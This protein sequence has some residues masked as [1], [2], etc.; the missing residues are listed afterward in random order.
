MHPPHFGLGSYKNIRS[1]VST[2]T[3][4]TTAAPTTGDLSITSAPTMAQADGAPHALA[5]GQF[6]H[7]HA[8]S[9]EAHC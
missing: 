7:R 1:S 4:Y 9:P 5:N 2:T 6:I 3:T 8:T